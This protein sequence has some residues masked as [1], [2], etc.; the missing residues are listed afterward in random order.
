MLEWFNF[1]KISNLNKFITILLLYKYKLLFLKSNLLL[2]FLLNYLNQTWFN[3]HVQILHYKINK[4][5]LSD[6]IDS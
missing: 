3:I 1:L 4:L 5:M 6:I 2:P